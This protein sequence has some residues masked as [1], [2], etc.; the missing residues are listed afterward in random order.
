MQASSVPMS[1]PGMYSVRLAIARAKDRTRRSLAARPIAGSAQMPALPPPKA[2]P[3][4]AF[5][6]VI[7]RARRATSVTV[8]SRAIRTPPTAGPAARLSTTTTACSPAAAPR[9]STIFAGP[10]SSHNSSHRAS[11]TETSLGWNASLT[12]R[13]EQ[14]HRL[15]EPTRRHLVATGLLVRLPG[16]HLHRRADPGIV[17]HQ[18]HVDRALGQLGPPSRRRSRTLPVTAGA[19]STCTAWTTH[20]PRRSRAGSRPARHPR[21]PRRPVPGRGF[22]CAA[23]RHP[24]AGPLRRGR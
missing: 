24:P 11:I 21:R 2:R 13:L 20:R 8:T 19:G 5:F 17:G 22:A 15:L 10:R 9:S 12:P 16:V 4:A 7:A 3:A 18:V 1:G 6:N 23:R 14:A